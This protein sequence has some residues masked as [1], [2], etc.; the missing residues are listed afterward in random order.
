VDFNSFFATNPEVV[1]RGI[2][3]QPVA[4]KDFAFNREDSVA[5]GTQK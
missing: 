2:G 4:F 1:K 5:K 3:L